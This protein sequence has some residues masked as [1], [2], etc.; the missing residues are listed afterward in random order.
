MNKALSPSSPHRG[1][2]IAFRALTVLLPCL[3]AKVAQAEDSARAAYQAGRSASDKEA[4][5]GHFARGMSIAQARLASQPEDAEG[6]YWLAVNMGAHALERGK[7]SALPVVPRMEALLLRLDRIAPSYESAG[8]ARV[9]GRLYHQAPAFISVG[10]NTK[11]RQ[12]LERAM[13]L[14]PSH[15][16]NLAFAADF[17]VS[18]GDKAIARDYAGRCLAVLA[19]QNPGPE[20]REWIEL[21]RGVLE[22]TR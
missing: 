21:A 8:A 13:S 15:P 20:E 7:M 19:G 3:T 17:L 5:K 10:S 16:G 1:L 22:K 11:A 9:L 4:R 18:H 6:L 2:S 12:F 14:A